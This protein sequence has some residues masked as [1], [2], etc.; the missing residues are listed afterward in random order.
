MC[1]VTHWPALRSPDTTTLQPLLVRS[2]IARHHPNYCSEW[3]KAVAEAS[4]LISVSDLK[5]N[6][7]SADEYDVS[8]KPCDRGDE[9]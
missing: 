3:V 1:L 6:A 8:S 9:S 4:S 5:S 7:Y 2:F